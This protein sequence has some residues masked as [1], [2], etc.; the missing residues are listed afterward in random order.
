MGMPLTVWLPKSFNPLR[1]VRVT[2]AAVANYFMGT[3]VRKTMHEDVDPWGFVRM[4]SEI[5][6]QEI[7]YRYAKIIGPLK[8]AGVYE[9]AGYSV[10]RHSTG[11]KLTDRF[12]ND[13]FEK[14]TIHDEVL[15]ERITRAWKERQKSWLPIHHALNDQQQAITITDKAYTVIDGL[16]KRNAQIC[17][18]AL[19]ENIR[20]RDWHFSVSQFGRVFNAATGLTQDVRNQV[21]LDGNR[22]GCI[23]IDCCQPALLSSLLA[24]N[25]GEDGGN[26][27]LHTC[28]SALTLPSGWYGSDVERFRELSCRGDLYDWLGLRCNPEVKNVKRRVL[29]D[30]LAKRGSYQSDVEDQFRR[31][32]PTV[33]AAIRF[34]NRHDHGELIRR[35]QRLESTLVIENIAP[36]LLG[37][38]P[39]VTVHDAIY[40]GVDD[41]PAVEDAFHETFKELGFS[42]SLKREIDGQKTKV[43][44]K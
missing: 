2:D 11:Y 36:L 27:T 35:L 23:D 14:R 6:Q 3:L 20:Q 12:V 38:F 43:T 31:D 22:I 21:R 33:Y 8:G 25:R 18:R 28:R 13:E 15:E 37:R 32:F 19:V 30:V 40:S 7:G 26:T 39:F 9:T 16:E 41:L 29:V 34:I 44:M 1:Y 5:L 4:H 24:S 42:I 10:G 17:Q